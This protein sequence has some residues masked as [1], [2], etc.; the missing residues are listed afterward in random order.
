MMLTYLPY[1]PY[2][3]L[4][5]FFNNLNIFFVVLAH[6]I[7]YIWFLSC[8]CR[9]VVTTPPKDEKEKI[10]NVRIWQGGERSNKQKKMMGKTS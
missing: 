1:V 2:L 10:S 3:Y 8:V 5:A 6:A 9:S 4:I 7:H